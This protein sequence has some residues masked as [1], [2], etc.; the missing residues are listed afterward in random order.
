MVGHMFGNHGMPGGFG[1]GLHAFDPR[2]YMTGGMFAHQPGGASGQTAARGGVVRG[3]ADG[4]PPDELIPPPY[5]PRG[6]GRELFPNAAS[7]L[8][9]EKELP[10]PQ[11]EG[12]A[13][14]KVHSFEDP[15]LMG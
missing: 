9:G 11:I 6:P 14:G 12:H 8:G 15:R 4:G 10:P 2:S 3:Y 5:D 13:P 7:L 1:G